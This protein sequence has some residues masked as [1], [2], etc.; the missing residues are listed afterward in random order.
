MRDRRSPCSRL[1]TQTAYH[2]C[3]RPSKSVPLSGL[4]RNSM[5]AKIMLHVGSNHA[6]RPMGAARPTAKQCNRPGSQACV[7]TYA[8]KLTNNS[9]HTA[10]TKSLATDWQVLWHLPAC[11]LHCAVHM[12]TTLHEGART[13]AEQ[14]PVHCTARA[15]IKTKRLHVAACCHRLSG[16]RDGA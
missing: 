15:P 6:V 4:A 5:Q 2:K 16:L 10:T 12:T 9:Q 7:D 8:R 1:Q 14:L 13:A 11:S 3:T